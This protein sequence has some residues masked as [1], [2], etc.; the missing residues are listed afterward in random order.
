MVSLQMASVQYVHT[1][2]FQAE[3]VA[4]IH[5][6]TQLQDI[7]GR[8]RAAMEGQTVR[9]SPQRAS[10][11]LLDIE[12]GAPVIV[13]PESSQSPRV[14]VANFGQLR[15][16]NRFLPAGAS[17]T[18]SLRD[19]VE[20]L[21]MVHAFFPSLDTVKSTA[22]NSD[23]QDLPE[24][25]VPNSSNSTFNRPCSLNTTGVPDKT[26]PGSSGK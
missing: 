21:T 5:H 8:Q 23:G 18:F 1:Q 26:R 13:I 19:K 4:F 22:E 6:F 9:D 16:K 3:L 25:S 12:A 7:L 24:G 17:G 15:V 20:K 14:I 10:R 11:V 2:R